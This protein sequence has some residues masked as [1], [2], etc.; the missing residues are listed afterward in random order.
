MCVC[1]TCW[2]CSVKVDLFGVLNGVEAQT[3][4]LTVVP[5]GFRPLLVWVASRYGH[6][7]I[8]VTENGMDR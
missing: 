5:A 1:T 3:D 6:P 4:W 8:M 2:C 7:I